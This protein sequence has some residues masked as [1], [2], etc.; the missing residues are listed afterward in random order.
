MNT[1]SSSIAS[2]FSP[3]LNLYILLA[4]LITAVIFVIVLSRKG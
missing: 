3:P 2:L 1:I 4:L